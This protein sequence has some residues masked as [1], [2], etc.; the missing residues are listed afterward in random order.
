[1]KTKLFK[2]LYILFCATV[3]FLVLGGVYGNPTAQTINSGVWTK[4]PFE[5]A[6][7]ARYAMTYSLVEEGKLDLLA[8]F[9]KFALPDVGY[10][11]GNYVSL[12]APGT[13]FITVPGYFVGKYF[14]S[15]QVGTYAVIALFAVLNMAFV[16]LISEKLGASSAAATVTSFIFLFATP[17]FSYGVNLY[18]HHISLFLILCS[19]YLLLRKES[20]ISV[21]VVWFLYGLAI[22]VD[23]PNAILMLPI[24]FYS[25]IKLVNIGQEAAGIRI[26]FQVGKA[27]GVCG[28][29]LP[30]L[31]LAWFNRSLL[32]S[33]YSLTGT[34][35]D[36][37]S[38]SDDGSPVLYKDSMDL[39]EQLKE[40]E[41]ALNKS[42]LSF[43]NTRNLINGLYTHLVSPDRG[44]IYYAPVILFGVLGFSVLRKKKNT[45]FSF[46]L[47][48][49]GVDII[50]YSMWGD[51]WGGWSFGSRYLIP[52][53][54]LMAIFISFS[55]EKINEK[56]ILTA[57]FIIIT[58][59]SVFVNSLGAVTSTGNPPLSEVKNLGIQSGK[60]ERYTFARNW[61]ILLTVGSKSFVYNTF[62]A[63]YMSAFTYYL[64]IA[65]VLV[66]VS[67]LSMVY[68]F[69]LKKR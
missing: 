1:M 40:S 26:R 67:S 39:K 45:E 62:A 10:A 21:F 19:I 48:I 12:F 36:V 22:F 60:S 23:Y 51:P 63:S 53:Y 14:G 9:A 17:A 64:V 18:Q 4:G 46:L 5:F 3:L 30:I 33:P 52:A 11:N 59:Y 49:I 24:I 37:V 8:P 7:R 29:V 32:G 2:T 28:L 25:L 27:L 55:L 44:V 50:L 43:F 35:Q 58:A 54:A 6:Q 13:S 61:D 69:L 41:L 20:I 15:S 47:S 56:P 68:F 66:S 38:V 34:A 65:G 57:L 42:A 16:K 31:L